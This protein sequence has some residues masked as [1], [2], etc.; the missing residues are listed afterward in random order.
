MNNECDDIV[1]KIYKVIVLFFDITARKLDKVSIYDLYYC[2]VQINLYINEMINDKFIEI[3]KAGG[4]EPVEKEKSIFDDYDKENGY[5]D[6]EENKNIYEVYKNTLNCTIKYAINN[7]KMSYKECI[8]C[9][10]S[11][12]LDYIVFNIRYDLENKNDDD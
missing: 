11:E 2:Y 7:L 8:E 12:M 1:D 6:E 3:N 5:E 10:L 9:N 4:N